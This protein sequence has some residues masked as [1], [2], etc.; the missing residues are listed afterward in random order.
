MGPGTV[1]CRLAQPIGRSLASARGRAAKESKMSRFNPSCTFPVHLSS[2][3]IAFFH[4]PIGSIKVPHHPRT[5]QV[6][7]FSLQACSMVFAGGVDDVPSRRARAR[8][9]TVCPCW[10][11]LLKWRRA[12]TSYGSRRKNNW[13]T[14]TLD[15][16]FVFF[17]YLSF[18]P[19]QIYLH[20][21]PNPSSPLRPS[22]LQCTV[23]SG[24]DSYGTTLK[25]A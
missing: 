17:S 15:Y 12:Q 25:P 18:F 21:F 4:S 13:R 24:V 5:A 3:L 11:C 10:P 23:S 1:V 14:S 8:S 9:V 16:L 19:V 2:P 20:H 7:L 22:L 6:H